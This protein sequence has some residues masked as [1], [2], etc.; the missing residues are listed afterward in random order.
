MFVCRT[1]R[2]VCRL[3]SKKIQE[4]QKYAHEGGCLVVD[5]WTCE[6]VCMNMDAYGPGKHVHKAVNYCHIES[7]DYA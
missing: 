5:K 1:T 4:A 6:N 2:R 3:Q 7:F